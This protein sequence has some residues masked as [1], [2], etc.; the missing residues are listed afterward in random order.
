MEDGLDDV[1]DSP[2]LNAMLAT[3]IA[4]E[5]STDATLDRSSTTDAVSVS[6]ESPKKDNGGASGLKRNVADINS[7]DDDDFNPTAMISTQQ[8]RS[9]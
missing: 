8:R 5:T 9:H 2:V 3:Q 4:E 1:H 7:S 6:P